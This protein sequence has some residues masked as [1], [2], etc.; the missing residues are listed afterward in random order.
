V[1]GVRR[2]GVDQGHF[3]AIVDG[4]GVDRK[5][6]LTADEL[7]LGWQV[8]PKDFIAWLTQAG[9]RHIDMTI[10]QRG[11][12][13]AA[14]PVRSVQHSC[15]DAFHLLLPQIADSGPDTASKPKK[16][17]ATGRL[18]PFHADTKCQIFTTSRPLCHFD[19]R[20]CCAS[21]RCITG[22]NHND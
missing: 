13:K 4:E 5:P 7:N 19:C 8:I 14:K 3:R 12:D 20:A 6:E 2:A 9:S 21:G 15:C 17:C 22:I 10:A 1:P 16:P 11:E 18:P